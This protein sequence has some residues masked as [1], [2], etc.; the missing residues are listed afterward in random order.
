MPYSET[1]AVSRR[2]RHA[3]PVTG[4]A[5]PRTRAR[6]RSCIAA[7]V[8]ALVCAALLSLSLH[9][10]QMP[11]SF[12]DVLELESR[13]PN[14]TLRYGSEASH[15]AVLWV[16]PGQGVHPVVILIHGGCWL[17]EYD[18]A[19]LYPL[20]SRLAR[21][22]YAVFTPEYRRVGEEGGGWPGTPAD[23]ILAIDALAALQHPRLALDRTVVAGHSA[24]GHLA[25]WL[26]A[27]DASLWR[28]PLKLVAALGLAAI[29]DLEAYARGTNSCEVATPLFM[30]G[31][32]EERPREYAAASPHGLSYAVPLGLM[33]GGQ[34]PIVPASQA[35]ALPAARAYRLD[36]AGHF[37]WVH[38]DTEAFDA[39]RDA[40]FDLLQSALRGEA[41]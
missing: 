2:A 9:G 30:G 8:V 6:S 10:A 41:E 21:D 16:P 39:L 40:I 32:P 29:T 1:E 7:E 20:A 28:P 5:L 11:V 3:P 24:G 38:P 26:A 18:M 22:G 17:A 36:G 14:E 37:D 33:V 23:L 4:A 12:D 35:E 25:L 34:D 27:R 15:T 31:T 19:Y 13:A